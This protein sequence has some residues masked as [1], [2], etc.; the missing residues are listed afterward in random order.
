M[1]K[2]LNDYGIAQKQWIMFFDNS[3]AINITKN[4]VQYSKNKHID[5]HHFI[6]ELVE[7]GVVDLEYVTI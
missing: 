7:Q 6:R 1:K 5:R 4:L 2:T 3:S